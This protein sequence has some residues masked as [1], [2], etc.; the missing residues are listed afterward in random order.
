MVSRQLSNAIRH[1]WV[2]GAN[3]FGI[4]VGTPILRIVEIGA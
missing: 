2:P 3:R 1:D 4:H